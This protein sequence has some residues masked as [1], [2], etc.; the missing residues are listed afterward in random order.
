MHV[1]EYHTLCHTALQLRG[2]TL[3][4]LIKAT[5]ALRQPQ[6]FDEFLLACEADARGRTGF[7]QR[8]YPQAAYLRKALQVATQVRAAEF[9]AQGIE[10]KALGEAITAEQIN[11]LE[12]FRQAEADLHGAGN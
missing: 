10:G 11:R 3:L 6:R 8:A 7:E 4:K 5:G 1:C 2:K 12:H 9:T